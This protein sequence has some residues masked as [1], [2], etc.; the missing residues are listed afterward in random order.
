MF[1][2]KCFVVGEIHFGERFVYKARKNSNDIAGMQTD[3]KLTSNVSYVATHFEKIMQF[4]SAL[5][6]GPS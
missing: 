5:N 4:E 2:E 3:F 1:V 6:L